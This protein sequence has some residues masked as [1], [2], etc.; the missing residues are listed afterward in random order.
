VVEHVG[1][2][3]L[4]GVGVAENDHPEGIADQQEVEPAGIEQPRRGEIIGGEAGQSAAG[5]L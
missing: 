2:R 1:H 5:G 4:C 3:N